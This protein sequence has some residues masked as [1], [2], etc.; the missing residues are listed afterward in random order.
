[1]RRNKIHKFRYFAEEEKIRTMVP[2]VPVPFL[3]NP[4][5]DS[6][7]VFL[8]NEKALTSICFGAVDNSCPSS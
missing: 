6:L 3:I 4:V 2:P 8:E 1:M 7:S 5:G